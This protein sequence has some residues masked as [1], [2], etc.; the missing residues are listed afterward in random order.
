MLPEACLQTSS[1]ALAVGE[2][3]RAET[4]LRRGIALGRRIK[5]WNTYAAAYVALGTLQL[6][7]ERFSEAEKS[8]SVAYRTA[9]RNSISL[10]RRDAAY[11]LMQLALRHAERA[12]DVEHDREVYLRRA[13]ELALAAVRAC[14]VEQPDPVP[15]LLAVAHHAIV[16]GNAVIA[17]GTLARLRTIRPM[18]P[19]DALTVA[20]MTARTAALAGERGASKSADA[21]AWEMLLA[22]PSISEPAAF[23]AAV[24]LAHGAAIRRDAPSLDRATRAALRLAPAT[25]Y[26]ATVQLVA[27]LAETLQRESEA[28]K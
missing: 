24:D 28:G 1:C 2:P 26:E 3:L 22:A 17:R 23:A 6:R 15:V 10:V 16:R 9:R 27:F 13:D 25:E 12:L 8:L 5:D 21:R 14:D 19:E 7:Q 20:A 4:W 11:G 18:A